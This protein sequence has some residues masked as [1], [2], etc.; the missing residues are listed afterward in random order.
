MTMN[1]AVMGMMLSTIT[2]KKIREKLPTLAASCFMMR[3]GEKLI[4]S[5][6]VFVGHIEPNKMYI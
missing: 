2:R 5:V 6:R 1:C 3:E 4:K